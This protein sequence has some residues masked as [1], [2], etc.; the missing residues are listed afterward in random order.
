MFRSDI[1]DVIVEVEGISTNTLSGIRLARIVM[2]IDC[3]ERPRADG[4]CYVQDVGSVR[5]RETLILDTKFRSL[6]P[7]SGGTRLM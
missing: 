1:K 4:D 3:E 5:N 2:F 6:L 7:L